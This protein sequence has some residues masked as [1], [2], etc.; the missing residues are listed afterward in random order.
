MLPA[1]VPV[2]SALAEAG[3][4]M[5]EEVYP[6]GQ[7]WWLVGPLGIASLA[8]VWRLMNGHRDWLAA[9]AAGGWTVIGAWY[10]A[11]TDQFN[12]L[13]FTALLTLAL[14]SGTWADRKLLRE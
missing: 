14:V 8:G 9:A 4:H 5:N 7:I 10:A 13:V 11:T 12:M 3:L 2:W 6:I 1:G